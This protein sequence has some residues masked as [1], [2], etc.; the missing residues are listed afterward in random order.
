MT[1]D[2]EA[3]H[4]CSFPDLPPGWTFIGAPGPCPACGKTMARAQAEKLLAE[5]VK[6]MNATEEPGGATPWHETVD[7]FRRELMESHA[8]WREGARRYSACARAE[9]AKP[10]A[11]AAHTASLMA[12]SYSYALAAVLAVARREFGEHVVKRLAF[13]AADIITD[14]DDDDLNADVKPAE[15]TAGK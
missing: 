6:A 13:K 8:D 14:G 15:A 2:A 10:V 4:K 3:G 1:I 12:A 5:A 9:G 7:D 11:S